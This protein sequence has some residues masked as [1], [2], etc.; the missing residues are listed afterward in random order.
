MHTNNISINFEDE[1]QPARFIERPNRF[2]LRCC[3]E[4]PA[5]SGNYSSKPVDV[6]L[7]DPGR[8]RELLIPGKKLWLRPVFN[9]P[10]RLT[11]WSAALV[12]NPAGTGL[13]SI[14]ST[15]PNRLVALALKNKALKEFK[16]WTLEKAEYT[17]GKSRIDFLLRRNSKRL[18]LEVK[19]VTLVEE[20]TAMFPDAVTAR[21]ARHVL[22]LADIAAQKGWSTALLFVVQRED[23]HRVLA[24]PHIDPTFAEALQTAKQSGVKVLGVRCKV[25][26]HKVSLDS[27]I[28]A[29]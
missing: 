29:G 13:V 14:D 2:L 19:S 20:E 10:K 17:I 3:L 23:A 4:Y 24:A 1:L 12:E 15:L 5:E 27:F 18:A 7:P 6:H 25:T 26:P 11:R 9:N 22:E 28:P 21:G 16:D 8:L